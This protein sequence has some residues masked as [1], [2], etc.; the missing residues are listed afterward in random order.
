MKPFNLTFDF[1]DLPLETT[2][3]ASGVEWRLEITAAG[4]A[5][6][7]YDRAG[8][9][10]IGDIEIGMSRQAPGPMRWLNSK[11]WLDRKSPLFR[12]I[13]AA[14]AK[15]CRVDIERSIAAAMAEDGLGERADREEHGTLCHA[16]Q[17]TTP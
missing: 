17:G 13:S 5:Q 4:T 11:T 10:E 8:D 12:M 9:W 16:I 2:K 7:E 6:V 1:D 14:L 3:D 15:H